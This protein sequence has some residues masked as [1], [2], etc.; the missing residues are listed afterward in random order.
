M[1]ATAALLA[2]LE[3]IAHETTRMLQALDSSKITA[4]DSRAAKRLTLELRESAQGFI[5]W[6]STARLEETKN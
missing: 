1:T 6:L 2:S 4:D 3:V 5:D